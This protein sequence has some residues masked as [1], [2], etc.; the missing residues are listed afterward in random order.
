MNDSN[1]Y[2]VS[3]SAQR[4]EMGLVGISSVPG[5]VVATNE[6]EAQKRAMAL[7][8]ETFPLSE[9]YVSHQAAI[10]LIPNNHIINAYAIIFYNPQDG[11]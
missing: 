1:L 5:L 2:A 9:G 11:A 3:M 10:F 7:A 6:Y 8:R 4:H